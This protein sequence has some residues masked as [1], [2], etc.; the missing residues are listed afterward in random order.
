MGCPATGWQGRGRST[1]MRCVDVA[2]LFAA[3]ILRRNPDSIIVPFDTRSYSAKIDPSDSILSLAERL[4]K[5]GGGGTDCSIPLR[6]ANQRYSKRKFAGI[7][8]VS[9]N[10]S[11]INAGRPFGFGY[12]GSTGVMTEWESFKKTQQKNGVADPKLICIDIAPYGH[13][14]APD[15]A[16][17]LNIGGF[18]DAVFT[19][20]SAF[21][22]SD[23]ARFVREV[24]SVEL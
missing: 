3:A 17:I 6:E 7:V 11:W 5:Y 23:Q 2:A 13:T 16:D 8:L 18:S 9:D 19:V 14:Q 24:E 10:E 1:K 12:N 4:S 22:E 15:R 21:L 20:V